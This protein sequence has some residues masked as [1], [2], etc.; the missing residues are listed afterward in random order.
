MGLFFCKK[1]ISNVLYYKINA[2]MKKFFSFTSLFLFST[3]A[4]QEP[5]TK[6]TYLYLQTGN[7][8]ANEGEADYL[9]NVGLGCRHFLSGYK[10][11]DAIDWNFSFHN[12]AR[13]KAPYK[14]SMFPRL[15]IMKH[16]PL[17]LLQNFYAGFGYGYTTCA[18]KKFYTKTVGEHPVALVTSLVNLSITPTIT[19]G[20]IG[21]REKNFLDF[22]ELS[23]TVLEPQTKEFD[24][25]YLWTFSA[26]Y[27]F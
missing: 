7:S 27:G 6:P 3:I 19:I 1:T 10:Y 21:K 15:S 18:Y 5:E 16:M 12:I 25:H 22:T 14:V 26:G 17:V 4:C 2:L 9:N 13:S 11:I 24:A 20:Y 23:L 8:I